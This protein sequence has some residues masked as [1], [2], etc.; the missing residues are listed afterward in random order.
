[1]IQTIPCTK[2][3]FVI[4][5]IS[6]NYGGKAGILLRLSFIF[7]SRNTTFGLQAD[8]LF[9]KRWCG[10]DGASYICYF[11]T[12]IQ[13]VQ[14]AAQ[15]LHPSVSTIAWYRRAT[16]ENVAVLVKRITIDYQNLQI[17]KYKL[18]ANYFS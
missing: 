10:L 17:Q 4:T 15:D 8:R 11:S 2:T 13:A 5:K 18:Q 1:M 12:T 9:V 3:T 7:F 14:P 6:W 16:C